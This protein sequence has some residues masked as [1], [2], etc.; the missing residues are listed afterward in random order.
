MRR[1]CLFFVNVK[2]VP[3]IALRETWARPLCEACD[4]T[5]GWEG[6][7]LCRI[8]TTE[9]T[10][11]KDA[12]TG[13]HSHYL[14]STEEEASAMSIGARGECSINHA[15]L[16]SLPCPN[17][18]W[19]TDTQQWRSAHSLWRLWPLIERRTAQN[20]HWAHGWNCGL[21]WKAAPVWWRRNFF[22]R[23][24]KKKSDSIVSLFVSAFCCWFFLWL[25]W[26]FK[27]T[28]LFVSRTRLLV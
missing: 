6:P 23:A 4:K 27:V 19:L 24:K 17:L 11:E 21:T 9:T 1:Q 14:C 3:F 8:V 7:N 10:W 5:S 15:G 13:R 28:V 2:N 20:Y 16:I 25:G 26:A 18:H 22:R 12:R